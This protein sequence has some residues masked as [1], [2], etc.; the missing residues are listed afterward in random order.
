MSTEG[1]C[2]RD[3]AR[4]NE[5]PKEI[6]DEYYRR[7]QAWIPPKE[8]ANAYMWNILGDISHEKDSAV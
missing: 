1:M 4:R 5:V 7:Q 8:S 2:A 6:V 3:F